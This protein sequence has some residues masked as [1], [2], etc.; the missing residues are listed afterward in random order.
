MWNIKGSNGIPSFIFNQQTLPAFDFSIIPDTIDHAQAITLPIRITSSNSA[1]LFID[2]VKKSFNPITTH[3]VS[4]VPNELAF[5]LATYLT[6]YAYN[7]NTYNVYGKP[8]NFRYVYI[9]QK[10]VYIK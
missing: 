1:T 9:F 5:P 6:L 3:S 7:I 10:R 8:M 2:T 4:Y